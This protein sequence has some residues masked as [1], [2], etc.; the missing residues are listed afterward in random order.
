[1]DDFATQF[2]KIFADKLA[3]MKRMRNHMVLEVGTKVIETTPF[4]TGALKGSWYSTL[5]QPSHMTEP[6]LDTQEGAL[7]IA[8]LQNAVNKWGDSGVLWQTNNLR[9]AEGVE[10]DSWSTQ[11]PAGMVRIN[12]AGYSFA[13]L[14]TGSGRVE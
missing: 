2:D 4:L 12:I 6:R 13:E 11:Q 1:M 10:F 8:D 9:Y 5:D 3:Y 7:A 14:R